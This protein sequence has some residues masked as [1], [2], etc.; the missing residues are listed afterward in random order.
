MGNR[1]KDKVALI[2]GG[3]R[4]IGWS[5]AELF[6]AE[7]ARIV[8]SD[9]NEVLLKEAEGRLKSAGAEG[10]GIKSDVT[11]PDQ[12]EEMVKKTVDKFGKINILVNNAGITRDGLLM[13]MSEADW[14]AVLSVN[15]KGAFLCSRAASKVMIKQRY[16]KIINIASIVG[17]R[18]NAGQANYA[19]SKGGLIALTKTLAK[20][21]GS[22]N[23]LVN[24]I[25]PGFIR[26]DMTDKLSEDSQKAILSRIPL[27]RFGEAADVA[28]TALF[29]PGAESDYVTGAVLQVDGGIVM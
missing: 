14:D 11:N 13:R 1:L 27:N 23:V 28:K 20:E 7:G 19:A 17:I 25:A 9:V 8:I 21:L 16:G 10:I 3:A 15:L 26:T 24:A 4:G 12:V 29:L 18:G 2:T 6:A 5:I 22:R